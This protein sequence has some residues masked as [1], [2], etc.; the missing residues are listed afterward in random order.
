VTA[1]VF[2]DRD[3]V[4][5]AKAPDGRYVTGWGGFRMLPGVDAALR[6]LRR[7]APGVRLIV[8]TNQRGVALGEVGEAALADIHARMA[9]VLS[10]AGAALDGIYVCPHA[11][12]ACD[13]R[14]PATGLFRQAR[15]DFP[16]IEPP[17]SAM[18]G[19]SLDDL[20]AGHRAGCAVY[21]VGELPR[22]RVVV[23]G[24]A[25]RHIPIAGEASSLEALV[26]TYAVVEGSG[27]EGLAGSA[28]VR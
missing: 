4:L 8:L 2:L 21:L 5:N 6:E 9:R 7:R 25:V 23:A 20:E 19:D 11:E 15:A 22:R 18:I 28:G 1:A 26:R 16:D 10:D 27:A 3:G 17:R 14:K 12:R 24:A 13:C